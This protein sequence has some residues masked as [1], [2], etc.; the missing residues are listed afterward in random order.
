MIH[1]PELHTDG[2]RYCERCVHRIAGWRDTCQKTG[3]ALESY[4]APT[5]C[6]LLPRHVD[7]LMVLTQ[8]AA[9]LR[10]RE[11]NA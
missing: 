5:W 7:S 11:R 4:I 3:N 10:E 6:P 8:C 1:G 9:R 2:V